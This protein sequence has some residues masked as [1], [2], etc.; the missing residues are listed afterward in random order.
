M[1]EGMGLWGVSSYRL[2]GPEG[3]PGLDWGQDR[4]WLVAAE[5]CRRASL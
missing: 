3:E 2:C 4:L 5:I 1:V